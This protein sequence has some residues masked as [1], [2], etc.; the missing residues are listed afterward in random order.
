MKRPF[1]LVISLSAKQY[2]P[3]YHADPK[4]CY[5]PKPSYCVRH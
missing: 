3:K 4:W 5:F 1:G 2:S